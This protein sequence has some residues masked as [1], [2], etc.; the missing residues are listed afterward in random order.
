MSEHRD[1][2]QGLRGVA[3]LLVVLGHAGVGFLQG[4]YV[5]VDVFF[6]LSGFLITG[7]LLSDAMKRGSVSLADFYIR[8]ARRIL[9]AAALTLV[10]T[11][12]VAYKLLN[13][14]RA[15]QAIWDSV[16]SSLF[17]ANI[18]FARA[19][20]DYFAR[21]QPPSP[22]Q[23]YWSLAVEEQFYLVWPALLSLALGV[24]FHRR[25]RRHGWSGVSE[26]GITRLLAVASVAAIASFVWSIYSTS[27][28][29][30]SAYFSTLARAWELGLGAVLAIVASRVRHVSARVKVAAGWLGLIAVGLA[31]VTFSSSTPFPGYAAL[32]PTVGAMLVIGAGIGGPTYGVSRLLA[33]APLRYVGDRS[34]AF[35]LWHWPVLTIAAQYEGHELSV[36]VNLLLL[37]GA[38]ALSIVSYGLFENPIRQRASAPAS[39]LLW[40]Y[41]VAAVVIVAAFGLSSIDDK[42][43]QLDVAPAAAQATVTP[44]KSRKAA[45]TV[46][47]GALPGVIAAVNAARAGAPIPTGLTPPVDQ[48]LDRQYIYFFPDGCTP[49]RDS[50][51]R[52]TICRMGDVGSAKSL[53]VIG[54]SHAQMWMPAI[55]A[56]A[57]RDGWEV[58]P[59]VKSGCVPATWLDRS[60]DKPACRAW[61]KWAVQQAQAIRPAVT[62]TSGYSGGTAG[63][64]ADATKRGYLSVVRS[65]RRYSNH[66]VVVADDDGVGKEPV[67]C[68]LAAHA[69]MRSCTTTW[70]ADQFFFNDDLAALARIHRFDILKTRGWFC[71]QS[72]CPMV[73]GRTVVYRDTGHITEPYALELASPFR[74]AFRRVVSGA[75]PG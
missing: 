55:L 63:S 40:P 9:P 64:F 21:G 30:A 56:L 72:Q 12:V 61:F 57:K 2:I 5:G 50:D 47:R 11:E 34:Y 44:A 10:V 18:H 45:A 67:D 54:D 49:A 39:A 28:E 58:R 33:V 42:A 70:P 46:A 71:Y 15:K 4:G 31:A 32:L 17:A 13:I 51:T 22:V 66:V 6:V 65:L 26:R 29:P 37:G 73:V 38:F 75:R 68:L 23:H 60:S 14:V 41:S 25:S 19:G 35:Y 8:R 27:I 3:V 7:L 59:I 48:L 62:L 20:T 74:A 1:D 52:S 36:G 16:W 69:T 43:L 24:V 53:V